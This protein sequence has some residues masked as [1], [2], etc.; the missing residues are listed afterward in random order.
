M[1]DDCSLITRRSAFTL[2]ELLVVIAIISILA[3]LLTPAL[4]SARETARRAACMN[5]LKQVGTGALLYAND[6]RDL[7][8]LFGGFD[9]N[10]SYVLDYCWAGMIDPYLSGKPLDPFPG[11][12]YSRV[13]LCPSDRESIDRVGPSG[14][15]YWDRIS[16]GI[17]FWLYNNP[18]PGGGVSIPKVSN[19]SQTLYLSE[20]RK[21]LPL[22]SYSLYPALYPQNTDRSAP[23]GRAR[24]SK[25]SVASSLGT[26]F[27]L[28]RPVK[29]RR[30]FSVSAVNSCAR[31]PTALACRI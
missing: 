29:P 19:S 2:I 4:S 23:A 24:A 31:A 3:A 22:D 15:I 17:S 30:C 14:L 11:R 20:H 5:N 27:H 13:F 9:P 7:L 10:G 21:F 1:T 25:P 18:T 6:N 26:A 28:S 16:Y 12:G 8:P